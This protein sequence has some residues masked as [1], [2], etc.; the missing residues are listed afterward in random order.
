M[1]KAKTIHTSNSSSQSFLV[2]IY[3][4]LASLI[5]LVLIVIG[6]VNFVRLGLN[7]VIG[8]QPYPR[9][10]APYPAMEKP[11]GLNEAQTQELTEE[12]R[13]A[14][15]EWQMRYDAW[16]EEEANFNYEAN[17]RKREIAT[18]LAMLIVGIP[19]FAL[20]APYVFRKR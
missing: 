12:Q 14:L 4:V 10:D 7:S 5:A 15:E 9:F 18:S 6:S 1:P 16:K 2:S 19:V 13:A 17:D 3:F 11:I 20:H 8:I